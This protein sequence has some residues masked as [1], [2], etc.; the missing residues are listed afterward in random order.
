[1]SE[2]PNILWIFSDELRADAVASY[3]NE[4]AA[5]RTPNLDRIS[6]AG[7]QFDRFYVNSPVCV[8]SR[9]AYKTGLLP[10]RTGVYHNE[11]SYL[12]VAGDARSFTEDFRDAGYLTVN[13]GKEHVPAVLEGF[14]TSFTEHADQISLM[15][16]TGNPDVDL[17]ITARAIGLHAATWPAAEPFPPERLT[18]QAVQ[19]LRQGRPENQPWML[20]VSYLQPHTPVVVPEPWA[21][22]YDSETWPAEFG[23]DEGLCDYERAFT[24]SVGSDSM[25]PEEIVASQSRYHGLV[26]WLDAQVGRLLDTLEAEGLAGDIVLVVASDH[27][28]QLGELGGAYGKMTFARP[29]HQVPFIVSWPGRLDAGT[30]RADLAQGVDLGSTLLDLAGLED[31]PG[32]DG[33]RLFRDP[34]PDHVLSAIGFGNPGSKPLPMIDKGEFPGG[35]G[36]PQRF[37]VRTGRWRYERSTRRDGVALGPKDHDPYL[38]DCNA[39]PREET[40]V[41]HDSAHAEV[42]KELEATLVGHLD[43]ALQVDPETYAGW[44]A[45]RDEQFRAR[46]GDGT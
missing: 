4:H 23:P 2:S 7:V 31:R 46:W 20:R 37:C 45:I 18:D 38:V 28:A 16:A 3:G 33:R 34:A 24:A 14:D 22:T 17:G 15:T 6:A 30:R 9:A 41:L 44:R 19:W 5:I 39:D 12:P 42:V 21:T 40:N 32:V 26:T 25:T 13:L 43:E 1:M 10:T 11:G 27:G 8:S 35:L 29:S 36:W